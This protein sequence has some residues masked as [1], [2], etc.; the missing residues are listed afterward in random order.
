[1]PWL[2][3]IAIATIAVLSHL[4][5]D[6]TNMYGI[7]MLLPFSERW[8]RLDITN[9]VDPW[10]WSILL[11]AVA[12]PFLSKLVSS[13]IG[14][15]SSSGRGWAWFA[16]LVLVF[17]EGARFTAHGRAIEALESRIYADGA[18]LRVAA[19]P[20]AA[21]PLE[22]TGL[23]EGASSWSVHTVSLLQDFDP[24][25]GRVFPKPDPS[26]ALEAARGTDVFR[27]YLRF[28]QWPAWRVTPVDE[29]E[30]GVRVDVVDL[31]FG[32]PVDPR[33]AAQ[34]VVDAA[35]RVVNSGFSF[36]PIR[37]ARPN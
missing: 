22:W 14:G 11:L 33:F 27:R 36:G 2:A 35:G 1:M 30:G 10:I 4:L 28:S 25:L 23:V 6:W 20:T 12:A 29:P 7:R 8:L 5:L 15:K 31:R 24:T 16:L 17:Y 37:P 34:A 32:T 26:P 9:V 19:M 13:E 3:G 18:P 21:N